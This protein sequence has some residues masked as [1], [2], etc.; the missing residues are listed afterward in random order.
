MSDFQRKSDAYAPHFLFQKG[1]SPY[2]TLSHLSVTA[3]VGGCPKGLPKSRLSLLH[4]Q[5]PIGDSFL[6]KIFNGKDFSRRSR[7]FRDEIPALAKNNKQLLFLQKQLY[8]FCHNSTLQ[9]GGIYEFIFIFY[10][11]P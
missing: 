5:S 7:D 2:S 9:V 1:Y 3:R 11:L 8:C 4:P 6:P 10:A